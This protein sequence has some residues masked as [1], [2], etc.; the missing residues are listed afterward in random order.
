M[1]IDGWIQ[2][3]HVIV[4]HIRLNMMIMYKVNKHLR[5]MNLNIQ[6]KPI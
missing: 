6:S 4:K 2:K 1:D 3:I 5:G